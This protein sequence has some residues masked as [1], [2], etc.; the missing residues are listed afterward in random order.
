MIKR[1]TALLLV[2]LLSAGLLS[3]CT[4]APEKDE[5]LNIVCTVF[6]Y[7]DWVKNITGDSG[8][9][10]ITLLLDSGTDLHS[11]QPTAA[12]IITISFALINIFYFIEEEHHTIEKSVQQLLKHVMVSEFFLLRD[13]Q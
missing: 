2:L 12:D 1:T 9:I 4:D 8:N 3:A 7:Y 10:D 6:P 11:Y 5:K 13:R